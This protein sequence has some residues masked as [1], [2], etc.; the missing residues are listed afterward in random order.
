MPW[1]SASRR[2]VVTVLM[3]L[4]FFSVT[5][6]SGAARALGDQEVKQIEYL[7]ASVEKLDGASFVR[8]GTHYDGKQAG[9]HLRM[10]LKKAGNRVK[11]AE[12][13]ITLCASKSYLSGKPYLIV[14]ADGKT[15][16]AGE[17]FRKKLK[18]YRPMNRDE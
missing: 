8:N 3:C 11:N 9:S 4:G 10:K 16:P 17:F 15:V 7:I 2:V 14:F 6:Y 18:E 5:L 13:F 12:D 1:M